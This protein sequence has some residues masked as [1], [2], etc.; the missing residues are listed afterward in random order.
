MR[1]LISGYDATRDDVEYL[2]GDSITAISPDGEVRFENAAPRRF[3]L[4]VGADGLHSPTCAASSLATST[5]SAPSSGPTSGCCPT[6]PASTA[7]SSSTSASDALPASTARGTSATRALFLLRSERELDYHHRDMPRQ[8][9]LLRG[10]FD[11]A[12]TPTWTAG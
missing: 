5:A 8:K 4:V 10:A 9:E 12:C 3:D 1:I 2:F 11:V 6:P 7:S